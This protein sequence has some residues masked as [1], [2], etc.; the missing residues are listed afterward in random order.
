[1]KIRVG[2]VEEARERTS[3]VSNEWNP[4]T[5]FSLVDTRGRKLDLASPLW[6]YMSI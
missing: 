1:M 5:A 6:A 3:M 4:V 2:L